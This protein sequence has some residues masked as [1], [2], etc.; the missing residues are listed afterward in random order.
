MKAER[1]RWQCAGQF[2]AC[3]G[4]GTI[5]GAWSS[6]IDVWLAIHVYTNYTLYTPL[7]EFEAPIFILRELSTRVVR[8]RCL[9]LVGIS[10]R[11]RAPALLPRLNFGPF[12]ALFCALLPLSYHSQA[13]DDG[14]WLITAALSASPQL[15]VALPLILHI[16]AL[17]ISPL[18]NF[19]CHL[20]RPFCTLF[21]F[22]VS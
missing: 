16:F 7:E 14:S 20:R 1:Y 8:C 4:C 17:L 2:S 13:V 18:A 22:H 5:G 21:H 19:I 3:A 15:C 11:R 10:N 6:C 9:A 12:T